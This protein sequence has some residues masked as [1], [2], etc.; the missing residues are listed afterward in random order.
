MSTSVHTRYIT[1][2][3]LVYKI[4]ELQLCRFIYSILGFESSFFDRK[5]EAVVSCLARF[6]LTPFVI[7]DF[8]ILFANDLE[9]IL[10][11]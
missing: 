1:E 4:G 10:S 9:G 5:P 3:R 7:R 6:A 8:T 2:S 11:L